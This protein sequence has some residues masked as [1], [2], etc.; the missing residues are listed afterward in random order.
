MEISRRNEVKPLLVIV[1]AFSTIDLCSIGSI[2][3]GRWQGE[4]Q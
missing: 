1:H 4:S 2:V 3:D